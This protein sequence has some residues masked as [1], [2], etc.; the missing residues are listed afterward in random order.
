MAEQ[1]SKNDTLV[2]GV[3][4]KYNFM[5][6][7]HY[8][9]IRLKSTPERYSGG[10]ESPPVP[11]P[12]SQLAYSEAVL[13]GGSMNYVRGSSGFAYG[14]NQDSGFESTMGFKGS[15]LPSKKMTLVELEHL[16]AF[17]P[18]DVVEKHVMLGSYMSGLGRPKGSKN[19][20]TG[21][22]E[23]SQDASPPVVE[24]KGTAG[25]EKALDLKNTYYQKSKRVQEIMD[26]YMKGKQ[27]G[28][29][30]IL[31]SGKPKKMKGGVLPI[32]SALTFLGKAFASDILEGLLSPNKQE[33]IQ[34]AI[35]EAREEGRKAGLTEGLRAKTQET[36][37]SEAKKARTAQKIVE[38][39]EE[40]ERLQKEAEATQANER[41]IKDLQEQAKNDIVSSKGS[42]KR[43]MLSKTQDVQGAGKID[44]R[45]VRGQ[46]IAKLMKDKKITFGEASKMYSSQKKGSGKVEKLG[47]KKSGVRTVYEEP[48]SESESES[49]SDVP[50]VATEMKSSVKGGRKLNPKMASRMQLVKKIMASRKMKMIEASKYIKANNLKY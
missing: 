13:R 20:K 4:E 45:K 22:G 11:V 7:S 43:K 14:T 6:G 15:G 47:S 38:A 10:S 34:K 27:A 39:P 16:G 9:A 42:G 29:S 50:P 41:A 40:A 46:A 18:E 26:R 48:E 32:F 33:A 23:D 21:A 44:G 12:E 36:I 5:G 35:T 30:T 25:Y 17:K 31:A 19:R 2:G 8:G 1:K 37:G 28:A 49:E 24:P 3:N